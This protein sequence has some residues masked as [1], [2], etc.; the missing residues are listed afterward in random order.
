MHSYRKLA[1]IV[2]FGLLA[3]C[4]KAGR[5]H[6]FDPDGSVNNLPD[7][8]TP[9]PLRVTLVEPDHGPV[10]GGNDVTIRGFGFTENMKVAFGGR[11]ADPT[12]VVTVSPNRL[13]V[14][15]PSGEVGPVEIKAVDE[16]GGRLSRG[17]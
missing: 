12:Q 5:V 14:R 10:E 8:E 13:L 11:Y 17:G 16:R 1:I 9:N 3:G 15:V 2:F 6:G 7:G 4:S